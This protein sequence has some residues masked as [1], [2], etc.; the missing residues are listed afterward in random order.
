MFLILFSDPNGMTVISVLQRRMSNSR[1]VVLSFPKSQSC[2][3]YH[4]FSLWLPMPSTLTQLSLCSS[5]QWILKDLGDGGKNEANATLCWMSG[6]MASCLSRHRHRDKFCVL[7]LEAAGGPALRV[8]IV[9]WCNQ[10]FL[11]WLLL[12]GGS[13][14]EVVLIGFFFFLIS[15]FGNFEYLTHWKVE[16]LQCFLWTPV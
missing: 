13:R 5:G 1:H 12:Q 8:L 6:S 11:G 14:K 3:S 7:W 15:S 16:L 9:S 2:G 4:S 10:S